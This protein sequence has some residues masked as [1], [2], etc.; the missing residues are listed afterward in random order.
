MESN[1]NNP[2]KKK[3]IW[4]LICL[5]FW[6]FMLWGYLSMV[7]EQSPYTQGL[8]VYV[9]FLILFSF[10]NY[11]FRVK[12]SSSLCQFFLTTVSLVFS[13]I[14]FLKLKGLG[15]HI[16]KDDIIFIEICSFILPISPYLWKIICWLFMGFFSILA[17]SNSTSQSQAHGQNNVNYSNYGY[18][19][20]RQRKHG[21][22]LC[23]YCGLRQYYDGIEGQ[24]LEGHFADAVRRTT[25]GKCD[26][27]PTGYHVPLETRL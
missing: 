7:S 9:F 13:F 16:A 26:K 19:P 20:R 24:D 1:N 14:L 22:V 5:L 8:N 12:N 18:S 2:R 4:H 11:I 25:I 21:Y 27:S 17:Y 10:V 15:N 6:S 3:Y 23:K